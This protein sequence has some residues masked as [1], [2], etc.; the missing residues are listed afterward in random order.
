MASGFPGSS[1]FIVQGGSPNGRRQPARSTEPDH[2]RSKQPDDRPQLPVPRTSS[3]SSFPT[4]AP[5]SSPS[6]IRRA[7]TR[8]A[9][10]SSSPQDRPGSARFPTRT[11]SSAELVSGAST[12]STQMTQ[13]ALGTSGTST[14]ATTP[15]NPIEISV[16]ESS[17]LDEPRRRRSTSTRPPPRRSETSRTFTVTATDP[18][19]QLGTSVADLQRLM[20]GRPPDTHDSGPLSDRTGRSIDIIRRRTRRS[21]AG[22]T[23]IFRARRARCTPTPNDPLSYIRRGGRPDD[24]IPRAT[25]PSRPSR[26]PS[27]A[28]ANASGDRDGDVPASSTFTGTVIPPARRRPRRR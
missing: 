19:H 21:A 28:T 7:D 11:G 15:G 23:D 12:S 16:G 2:G 8:T 9:R 26:A 24:S 25:P 13:V 20:S 10:S 6:P 27:T 4:P 5:A 17:R 3:T 22:Q 1:D 14:S 18:S